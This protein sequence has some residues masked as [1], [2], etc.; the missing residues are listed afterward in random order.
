M[1]SEPV[2]LELVISRIET[3]ST[4]IVGSSDELARLHTWWLARSDGGPPSTTV[5]A[6]PIDDAT[7]GDTCAA[8]QLGIRD[9]DRAIDSG[10]TLLVPRVS[11]RD[12]IACLTVIG[13]LTRSEPAEVV[14]Q[15]PGMTDR[16]WIDRCAAV[17]DEIT[18]LADKRAAPLDLL[19]ALNSTAMAYVIGVLLAGAARRTPS[20]VDGT[21]EL[22]SAVLADRLSFR[23]K[24]WCRAGSTSPDP[25]HGAAIDRLALE[26]GLPLDLDN[27]HGRGADAT[28]A[29]L[30]MLTA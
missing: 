14:F 30:A 13:L 25:A 12:P 2:D 18:T 22:A 17:R 7:T 15:H 24:E 9:A 27:D 11:V 6:S 19:E 16:E 20:L 29:L 8:L 21:D 10:A 23:A 1:T 26:R 3:P 5:L 28:I 4:E